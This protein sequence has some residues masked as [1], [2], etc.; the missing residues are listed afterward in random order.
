MSN[1]TPMPTKPQTWT[2]AWIAREFAII[3]VLSFMML[4][5]ILWVFFDPA[6]ITFI[7]PGWLF[8]LVLV[9]TA[10]VFACIAG[11]MGIVYLLFPN[12][13]M[14]VETD[15]ERELEAG[16]WGDNKG[17]AAERSGIPAELKDAKQ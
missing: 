8:G 15:V 4:T 5:T 9:C 12:W 7:K 2:C 13:Q 6:V 11:C 17:V 1:V 14:H 10:S 3:V 16:R